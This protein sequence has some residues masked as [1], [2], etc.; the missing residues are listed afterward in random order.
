MVRL[1]GLSHP[2]DALFTCVHAELTEELN[3]KVRAL[4]LDGKRFRGHAFSPCQWLN[5][6]QKDNGR[7]DKSQIF[8]SSQS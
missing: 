1:A 3:E 6:D 4:V 5:D 8:F 7:E 2:V